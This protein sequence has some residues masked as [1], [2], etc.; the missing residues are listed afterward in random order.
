MGAS[1]VGFSVSLVS[2]N[3]DK[4]HNGL[5][6]KLGLDFEKVYMDGR[7]MN[8]AQERVNLASK[9][10]EAEGVQSK[11]QRNNAWFKEKA[12]EMGLELDDNML[13][14]G[15][16]D[17]DQRDQNRLREA[18]KAKMRLH[19]LLQEPLQTQRYG[20]FLSTNSAHLLGGRG[21]VR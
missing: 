9:V 16:A 18:K 8:G 15:L 12:D 6:R 13:D 14:G 1:A 5:V 20:K 10:V 17:G 4:M 21:A 19:N 7:L 11:S 2:S 3:E